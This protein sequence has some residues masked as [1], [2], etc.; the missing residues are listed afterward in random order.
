MKRL[1]YIMKVS[2]DGFFFFLVWKDGS[3]FV[4]R[5]ILKR[6]YLFLWVFIIS[7]FY[8]SGPESGSPKEVFLFGSNILDFRFL[9]FIK[10]GYWCCITVSILI[11][12]RHPRKMKRTL[13]IFRPLIP[14]RFSLVFNEVRLVCLKVI[15]GVKGSV[16]IRMEKESTLKLKG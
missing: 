7:N 3:I 16:N 13:V 12:R 10:R 8:L 11:L 4:L 9:L 1:V 14:K 2:F 15:Y 5:R 6:S